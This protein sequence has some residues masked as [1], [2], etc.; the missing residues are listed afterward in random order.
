MK[1]SMLYSG[2]F[3]QSVQDSETEVLMKDL[4][5]EARD[6]ASTATERAPP[7]LKS[8]RVSPAV[9]G[10]QRP[11]H[12]IDVQS[13]FNGVLAAPPGLTV[14]TLPKTSDSRAAETGTVAYRPQEGDMRSTLSS[15]PGVVTEELTAHEAESGHVERQHDP[16]PKEGPD[17]SAQ[18]ISLVSGR[19]LGREVDVGSL[20]NDGGIDDAMPGFSLEDVPISHDMPRTSSP[21]PSSPKHN[22][23]GPTLDDGATGSMITSTDWTQMQEIWKREPATSKP[24]EADSH[25]PMI[26][27]GFVRDRIAPSAATAVSGITQAHSM[28]GDAMSYGGHSHVGVPAA[29]LGKRDL[30]DPIMGLT[31]M[32][33]LPAS[34]SE[35]HVNS[36]QMRPAVSAHPSHSQAT[37]GNATVRQPQQMPSRQ[38][39]H[40]VPQPRV[41][42][43]D[44][45]S[46]EIYLKQLVANAQQ[47]QQQQ[48]TE[49]QRVQQGALGSRAAVAG[50]TMHARG[51]SLAQ[52]AVSNQ[53]VRPLYALQY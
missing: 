39:G 29:Q 24:L 21:P 45:H 26:N 42:S 49:Q 3:M 44:P 11:V 13:L 12:K 30:V 28:L 10:V 43:A 31:A 4:I 1:F 36:M 7:G 35:K 46:F 14:H 16:E 32:S 22:I 5:A 33:L 9:E 6:D 27:D 15:V 2:L 40:A 19:K 51:P 34:S 20:F 8:N 38:L 25:Q 52:T 17:H 50:A 23:W 18:D 47:Q 41:D 48:I 37:Y 53:Q